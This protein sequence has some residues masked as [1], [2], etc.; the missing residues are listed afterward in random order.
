[1]EWM[2]SLFDGWGPWFALGTGVFAIIASLL[3]VTKVLG[4][5]EKVLDIVSPVLKLITE[6]LSAGVKWFW[7]TVIWPAKKADGTSPPSFRHG[8]E[9]ICDNWVTMATVIVAG[10]ILY[11]AMRLQVESVV[12]QLDFCQSENVRLEKQV[13]KS[14]GGVPAGPLDW[15]FKW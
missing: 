9:D 5:L 3:G 15:L 1:M 2:T 7:R 8:L 11:G 10:F 4:I 6:G 14:L 12:D 13:K